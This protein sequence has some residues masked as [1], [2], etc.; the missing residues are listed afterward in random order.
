MALGHLRGSLKRL[1]ARAAGPILGLLAGVACDGAEAPEARAGLEDLGVAAP[2]P[3]LDAGLLSP[4][5]LT[6]CPVGWARRARDGGADLCE[7]WPDESPV[8]WRCPEGWQGELQAGARVCFPGAG[9]GPVRWTCPEGWRPV[10]VEEDVV[11]CEPFPE[12][13]PSACP[14]DRALFPGSMDCEEV[15][16]PCPPGSYAEVLPPGPAVVY[17]DPGGAPGGDGRTPATAYRSLE[18]VPFPDLPEGAVIAL[19]KGA[20]EGIP[21]LERSVQLVGACPGETELRTTLRVTGQEGASPTVRVEGLA[22]VDL[23]GPGPGVEGP[24]ARLELEGVVIDG[25]AGPAL[26]A[27]AGAAISGR[28]LILRNVGPASVGPG[29]ALHLFLASATLEQVAIEEVAGTAIHIEEASHLRWTRGVIRRVRAAST[30]TD[31][32]GVLV[33]RGSRAE[34]ER[35]VVEQAAF[36]GIEVLGGGSHLQL[37]DGVLRHLGGEGGVGAGYGLSVVGGEAEI[38]GARVDE[39]RRRAISSEGAALVLRDVILSRTIPPGVEESEMGS[40]LYLQTGTAT[41]HQVA[42][43]GASGT[44]VTAVGPGSLLADSVRVRGAGPWGLFLFGEG[45]RAELRA[46]V[47]EDGQAGL[48]SIFGSDVRLYDGVVRDLTGSGLNAW[49]GSIQARGIQ[50]VRS[51]VGAASALRVTD[52]VLPGGFESDLPGVLVLEDAVLSDTRASPGFKTST[53]I[54]AFAGLDARVELRRAV[55]AGNDLGGVLARFEGASLT[56]EDVWVRNNGLTDVPSSFSGYGLAVWE[57]ASAVARN[58]ALDGNGSIGVWVALLGASLT[59]RDAVVQDT[60]SSAPGDGTGETRLPDGYGIIVTS[61][62]SASIA[63]ASVVRNRLAGA[64]VQDQAILEASDLL[65]LETLSTACPLGT[66]C[67]SG[68]IGSF[69]GAR[70]R[71]ERAE[72]VDSDDCGIFAFGAGDLELDDVLVRAHRVGLCVETGDLS[73]GDL[74][75]LVRFE[76]VDRLVIRGF[77]DFP[78]SPLPDSPNNP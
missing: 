37:R 26:S 8:D 18:E 17:V 4:P 3:P 51:S 59:M 61:S 68:G 50:V 41:I 24:A 1:R 38:L 32:T 29:S 34:L 75:R 11:A 33:Q 57:G 66:V 20:H 39:A 45:H 23:A 12:R 6:P 63:R 35:V 71:V 25:S 58:V 5:R 28:G 15:A 44:G 46:L 56:M 14:R 73:L 16:A 10:T 74:T 55:V 64:I 31:G 53:G 47:V 40:S 36:R 70:L 67:L 42:I 43:V 7:P 22:F 52:D 48:I 72:I 49:S 21:P 69:G 27:R 62:A 2:P 19:S 30:P 60:R 9:W 78:G 76:A 77:V 54:G 65:V 13:A